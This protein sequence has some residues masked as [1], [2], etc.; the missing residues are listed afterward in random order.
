MCADLCAPSRR[1]FAA[2]FTPPLPSPSSLSADELSAPL[3]TTW[4]HHAAKR[5]ISRRH[6]CALQ[7]HLVEM[8]TNAHGVH[9]ARCIPIGSRC[10]IRGVKHNSSTCRSFHLARGPRVGGIAAFRS[11]T[12]ASMQPSCAPPLPPPTFVL[13]SRWRLCRSLLKS[14]LPVCGYYHVAD[15]LFHC[16]LC[17]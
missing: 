16:V 5:Y 7:S 17:T 14:A 10:L 2:A 1:S 3:R 9:R 6:S 12:C 13:T 11:N 15:T 8:T 4:R